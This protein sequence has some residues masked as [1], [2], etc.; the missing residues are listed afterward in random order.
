MRKI[1]NR[2]AFSGEDPRRILQV[3]RA[4]CV[5]VLGEELIHMLRTSAI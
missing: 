4:H 3:E 2:N 1:S 5:L